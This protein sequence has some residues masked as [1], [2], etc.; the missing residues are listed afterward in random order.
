M[1][2][3]ITSDNIEMSP[4]MINL[5]HDKTK[6]LEGRLVDVPDDL[7]S[8]RIVMNSDKDDQFNVKIH[9]L[10]R[11]KEY[12][13]QELGYTLEQAL[14]QAVSN[15]DRDLQKDK[16]IST[17]EEWKETRDAKHFDPEIALQEEINQ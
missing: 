6:K 12:F 2:Y 1:Q 10:I 8:F 16:I 15:I 5:A 3:Q 7:K 13:S 17:E 11:G 4:S 9:A 14:I